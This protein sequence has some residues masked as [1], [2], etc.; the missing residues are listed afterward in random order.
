MLPKTIHYCWF[1]GN[2]KPKLAQKCIASWKKYCPDWEI[3]EWNESNFDVN[4]CA[5]TK[6]CYENK[7]YAYLS[8]YVRLW[9]VTQKGGIYFDTDVELIKSP[10]QLLEYGAFFGFEGKQY[11]N[12][13][14]GFGAAANH[15]TVVAMLNA[16]QAKTTADLEQELS[17]YKCL[18]GSPKMN[19]YALTPRGLVQNGKMQ[20]LQDAAILPE[21]FLCPFDDQTGELNTTPNSV[22]IHWYGKSANGKMAA[23]RSRVLRPVKRILKR[24]RRGKE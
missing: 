3:I 17:V 8:D 20:M 11:I 21:D 16:Y 7:R 15:W 6:F 9:A 1:G 5:Y 4:Q 22:S 18:T 13:G 10:D 24:I 12:T 19:T 23:F 14:L 2:P